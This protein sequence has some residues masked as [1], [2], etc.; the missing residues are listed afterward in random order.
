MKRKEEELKT[1]EKENKLEDWDRLEG[2]NKSG[3]SIKEE[4][5]L[6]LLQR[7]L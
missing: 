1:S 6:S 2:L 5:R 3:K 4:T 7:D